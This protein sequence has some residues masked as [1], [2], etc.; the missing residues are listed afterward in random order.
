MN[1]STTRFKL[2]HHSWPHV[3]ELTTIILCLFRFQYIDKANH[4]F[5]PE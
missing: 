1:L 5:V 2:Q 3:P 4:C